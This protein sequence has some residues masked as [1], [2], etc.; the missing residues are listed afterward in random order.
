[1]ATTAPA[2]PRNTPATTGTLPCAA[3]SQE[4]SSMMNTDGSRKNSPAT[5]PPR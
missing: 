2:M 5:A 3:A 4:S 1:M